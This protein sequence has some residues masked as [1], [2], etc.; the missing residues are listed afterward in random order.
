[1]KPEWI[2]KK[3]EIKKKWL[4]KQNK[5]NPCPIP[6]CCHVNPS[7]VKWLRLS[8]GSQYIM[9]CL[10]PFSS[11]DPLTKVLFVSSQQPSSPSL[12]NSIPY[13]SC[14]AVDTQHCVCCN[15]GNRFNLQFWGKTSCI[16]NG[17]CWPQDCQ[18]AGWGHGSLG[19]LLILLLS[20]S[21]L[22]NN[23]T[24]TLLMVTTDPAKEGSIWSVSTA[25]CP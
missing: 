24:Y 22:A 10:M 19:P 4:K 25:R 12:P 7:P 18:G 23:K 20:L 6:S 17:S 3:R 14:W 21:S 9:F 11:P 8:S 2:I 15:W 1:M 5:T 16:P 13:L